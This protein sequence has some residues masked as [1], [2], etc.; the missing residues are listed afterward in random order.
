[1]IS[2]IIRFLYYSLFFVL[3]LLMYPRTSELFEF[4]KMLLI[5]STA[6]VAGFLLGI[7]IIIK[8]KKVFQKS[9]LNWSIGIFLIVLSL[10]TIFSID[11]HTSLFGYYGRFNGGL[12]SIISYL[13]LF[14]SFISAFVKKEQVIILLKI[15]VLSSL[16]VILWGLPGKF[17]YDLSCYLFTGQLSNACWSDQFRP[18]DRIFSTL[19]QPN[20]L[21]AYLAINFFIA[22]YFF[23]SNPE[24]RRS[25]AH[26]LFSWLYGIYLALN[27]VG[28]LFTRSRSS[29]AAWAIGII[30]FYLFLLTSKIFKKAYFS[31]AKAVL[32]IFVCGIVVL[33]CKTGIEKIDR[34][35]TI[36]NISQSA[37]R[38]TSSHFSPPQ[39]PEQPRQ[40]SSEITESLDI[41][42]IVWK[43][44]WEL[45]FRYPLLGTGVETFAY[46]YYFTRPREHNLTS[47][48]DFI[49]NKAHNEYLNYLATTG[50]I[51]LGAYLL[52]ISIV[53]FNFQ[54]SIFK[55][56]KK[57]T[58]KQWDNSLLFTSLFIAYVTILITNIVGFSTT[59]VN[60]FFYLIPGFF[61]VIV[62]DHS[63]S[64]TQEGLKSSLP[65]DHISDKRP[66]T[67][68]LLSIMALSGVALYILL[69]LLNYFKGDMLYAQADSYSEQ[70]EYQKSF[71]AYDQALKTHYE[72][73]Y[74]DKFSYTLANVAYLAAYEKEKAT[75]MELIKLSQYFNQE[76][77][78]AA[79]YNVLYWKTKAKNAYLYYQITDNKKDL[80]EG[81]SAL[82]VG[83]KLSPGDPKIHYTEAILYD[84]IN[85]SDLA[86]IAINRSIELKPDFRDGYFLKAQLLKKY[87]KIDQSKKAA[88]YILERIN[89]HDDEA[90][91]LIKDL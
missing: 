84:L 1:M 75:A 17:G 33:F 52:M 39:S 16:L 68:E 80:E 8:K 9:A 41:R 66:K 34:Y 5:Y 14:Y 50:F 78:R 26:T 90:K 87:G 6:T 7:D 24:T 61:L 11:R 36:F 55:Q 43:G 10:S 60:L 81:L 40:L 69:F 42:K 3:P 47:E 48:W 74:Q 44:A 46:S 2:R 13:V 21:G 53:I 76:S 38:T 70:G 59:T 15:S 56:F 91:N 88:K 72:H 20:W 12:V 82:K 67:L 65:V 54:F 63:S 79:P 62:K 27:L 89:P 25:S 51:G 37:S 71:H 30:L 73:V 85:K 19:G 32:L 35:L 28:I 49:Y 29:L 31:I 4:N 64:K 45:G 86:L 83:E 57:I 22:L 23:N 18:Q 77:L 58:T